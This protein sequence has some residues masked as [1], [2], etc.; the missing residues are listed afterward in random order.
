MLI[1]DI[2][3]GGTLCGKFLIHNVSYNTTKNGKLYLSCS[4]SDKTGTVPAKAWGVTETQKEY[5]DNIISDGIISINGKVQSYNDELQVI[6]EE[7]VQVKNVGKADLKVCLPDN[8]VINDDQ[9]VLF[10]EMLSYTKRIKDEKIQKLV[11]YTL[12]EHQEEYMNSP[13]GLKVHHD[14]IGGLLIHTVEV[15]RILDKLSEIYPE[16][17]TDFLFAGTILHDFG[18]I[19]ELKRN[20]VG[21]VSDYSPAGTMLGHIAIGIE[22]VHKQGS[23]FD[24]PYEKLL[25]LEHMILSHHGESEYGS[26]KF[27]CFMEAYLLHLADKIS[28]FHDMYAKATDGLE[29][30]EFTESKQYF[31]GNQKILKL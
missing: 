13:A 28:C 29:S 17:N 3:D 30:G 15:L 20:K 11:A 14:V 21:L 19:Y 9:K 10:S 24:I 12:K 23:E 25:A 31:L 27:P 1:K 22:Y 16:V 18:K 7:Y 26:P 5:L 6:I 8:L 2:K 4:L